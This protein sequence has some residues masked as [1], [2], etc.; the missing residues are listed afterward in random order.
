MTED[1]TQESDA[2]AEREERKNIVVRTYALMFA[3]AAAMQA[4][5]TIVWHAKGNPDIVL[6]MPVFALVVLAIGLIGI[7]LGAMA[8]RLRPV[9]AEEAETVAEAVETA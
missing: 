5:I 6:S 1:S 7:V 4:I 8:M 2:T 3:F 9:E